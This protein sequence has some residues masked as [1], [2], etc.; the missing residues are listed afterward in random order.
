M[1]NINDIKQTP[2]ALFDQ[3]R[4]KAGCMAYNTILYNWSLGGGQIPASLTCSLPDLW[5]GSAEKGKLIC[6]GVFDL[7]GDHLELRG[8]CW[9]PVGV[10]EACLSHLH[11]FSWLRDLRA[12][13]GDQ[14]R[15]QAR[16]LVESWIARHSVWDEVFWRA[17]IL[18][19]RLS[20]W[21]LAHDFFCAN[22][23]DNFQYDFYALLMRQGR[24]LSRSLP[25][26]LNGLPLLKA[27]KG[28]VF[29]G[30]VLEGRESWVMHGLD[31]FVEEIEKQ[32][33]RDGGHVSRSPAQLL[34]VLTILVEIRAALRAAKLPVPAK[35]Q[36]AIDR[37]VPAFRFFRFADKK[38]ALFHGTQEGDPVF[39]DAVQ[40]RANARGKVLQSLPQTG[41]ER[42]SQGRSLL[43]FDTGKVPER[44][45]DKKFHASPLSFEFAYGKERIFVNCG[46]HP[47]LDTW[48]DMLR[49]TAAH[50]AA[51][52]DFRNAYEIRQDGHVGRKSNQV[53]TVRDEKKDSC[54]IEG[55]HSGY[56]SLNG[57]THRR[58]LFLNEQ[59]HDLRGEDTLTC[60]IG[61]SRPV[62][63]SI[64]FHLHPR[65]L[66]SLI[67][68]GKEALLRLPSGTGWRFFHAGGHLSLENSVYLG[69]GSS[70]VKTKQL[71]L[72][73]TMESDFA[74]VKWALQREGL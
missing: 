12:L 19:E 41:F 48:Q 49:G 2:M 51:F 74:Q 16:S 72:Y 56:V 14:A 53:L 27:I 60:S 73:G 18:G 20:H 9:A 24:H 35:I 25:A 32:V 44:Q 46:S 63:V 17:D 70:P 47:M 69:E 64:A 21:I 29:A 7:N 30:L 39:M 33:L 36:H 8:E 10:S 50:N 26:G 68:D 57:I 37:A 65:V 42:V 1:M 62:A 15:K 23:D 34:E 13:S 66:V 58:R 11:G 22:A 38:L 5:T 28:Y 61:L 3:L 45:Y 4:H 43:L 55:S 6:Q 59:G 40:N 52:L 71:I 54:L 67:R 31:L